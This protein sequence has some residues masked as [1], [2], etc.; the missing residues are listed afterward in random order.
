MEKAHDRRSA[1]A[2]QRTNSMTQDEHGVGIEPYR[3]ALEEERYAINETGSNDLILSADG[4]ADAQGLPGLS[5]HL[6]R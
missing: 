5:R 6:V 2:T 1:Q 3:F 4:G